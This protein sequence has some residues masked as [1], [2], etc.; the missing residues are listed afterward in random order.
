[1]KVVKKKIIESWN[2]FCRPLLRYFE[3]RSVV[4][5]SVETLENKMGQE[6]KYLMKN[7]K[8]NPNNL[9]HI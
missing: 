4:A 8:A 6:I 7:I 3:T 2:R 9:K 1:M 5:V